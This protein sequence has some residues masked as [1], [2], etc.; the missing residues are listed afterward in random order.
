MYLLPRTLA[1]LVFAS[2]AVTLAGFGPA[3]HA[4]TLGRSGFQGMSLVT[5][6]VLM[7]LAIGVVGVTREGAR[8]RRWTGAISLFLLVPVLA[9]YRFTGTDVFSPVVATV[10]FKVPSSLAGRTALATAIAGTL[11]AVALLMRPRRARASDLAAGLVV[12]MT[13]T[14]LLGYIYAVPDLN[15]LGLFNT[16]AS[17]SAASLLFLAVA[18]ISSTPG[19]GWAGV[20]SARGPGGGATRRQLAF[21]LL[22]PAAGWVLVDAAEGHKL[23][24][25]T[26]MAL[27]VLVT[28]WPLALLILR[29]GHSLVQLD[30]ERRS[31]AE[32]QRRH[33]AEMEERLAVQAQQLELV[34]AERSATEATLHSVQKMETLGQLTG[35][36]AHDFNNLLMAISGNL[37]LLRRR[38]PKDMPEQRHV[39]NAIVATDKGAKVTAQLLAFSRSQRLTISP[40]EIAPVLASACSLIGNALGPNIHLDV[41]SRPGI[42]ALTDAHQLELSL[43]NLAVNARDAMPNGGTIRIEC[44]WMEVGETLAIRVIDS[45]IG[46]SPEILAKATE[47]FFTTKPLGKG[48]GLGLA[49][50]HGFARQCEGDLKI[51]S[52]PG[53]GTV[54]EIQLKKATPIVVAE[55]TQSQESVLPQPVGRRRA[56]VVDD[57]EAVR[58]VITGALS[59][60][61]FEVRAAFD[62]PSGLAMLESYQPDVAVIDFLMPGMNGA[63][64]ARRVQ[65]QHKALPIVFVSGYADTVA[66]DGIA[67]AV[68]LKKPFKVDDLHLLVTTAANGNQATVGSR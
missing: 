56:L 62:G 39:E 53:V 11:S 51:S 16:M 44:E 7:L 18:I 49:Q 20:V 60:F 3:I 17:H 1:F 36:I 54:V 37:Q 67:N 47:P 48:T 55:I 68:V 52:E 21:L 33:S 38:L 32:M 57:D 28:V 46:M 4:V 59:E 12:V 61:G 26:A 9:S 43:L 22:P 64:L 58:E 24:F 66:L 25:G 30:R 23:G 27:M 14:A 34:S 8:I 31:R 10:F 35:G 19:L 5:A 15:A 6:L 42:W 63:E 2:G 45:G 13:A 65:S 29:D 41:K 50:V 40:T